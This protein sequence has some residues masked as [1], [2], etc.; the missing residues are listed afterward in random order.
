MTA[1]PLD[2]YS[3]IV[4]GVAAELTPKVASLRGEGVSQ[5]VRRHV[6]RQC[7]QLGDPVPKLAEAGHLP[8]ASYQ[9]PDPPC[10][11]S[12]GENLCGKCGALRPPAI[13]LPGSECVARLA[14]VRFRPH[15]QPAAAGLAPFHGG[16]G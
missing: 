7:P 2:A 4:A 13:A 6:R 5:H 12:C 16:H 8:V 1:E 9:A 11:G 15:D 10:C 3:Q 14:P